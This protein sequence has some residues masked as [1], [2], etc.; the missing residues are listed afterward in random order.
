[1]CACAQRLAHARGIARLRGF[2]A[3]MALRCSTHSNARPPPAGYLTGYRGRNTV[4]L[5]PNFPTDWF[6]YWI[7]RNGGD[8]NVLNVPINIQARCVRLAAWYG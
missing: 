7:V 1:M 3:S 4:G 6:G 8:F 2:P 5:T